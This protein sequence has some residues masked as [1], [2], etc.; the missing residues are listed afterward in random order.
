MKSGVNIGMKDINKIADGLFAA[1]KD[2][3]GVAIDSIDSSIPD[4]IRNL[5]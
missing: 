4:I 3:L 2:L 1:E 5:L